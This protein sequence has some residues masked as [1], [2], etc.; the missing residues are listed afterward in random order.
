MEPL[1]SLYSVALHDIGRVLVGMLAECGRPGATGHACCFCAA[2]QIALDPCMAL[3]DALAGDNPLLFVHA[4]ACHVT[5]AAGGPV[6]SAGMKQCV[7]VVGEKHAIEIGEFVPPPYTLS[8]AKIW[9]VPPPGG[10][11]P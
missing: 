8:P 3:G 6:D 11:P 9:I 4:S 7:E 5:M 2:R 1:R 10:A